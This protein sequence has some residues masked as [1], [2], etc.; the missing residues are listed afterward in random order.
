MRP[1]HISQNAYKILNRAFLTGC[2]FWIY[3]LE[4][5]NTF[6]RDP[7]MKEYL[8]KVIRLR[9]LWLEKFG[10]GI[11]RDDRGVVYADEGITAKVYLL[12]NDDVLV[13]MQ[14]N[15]VQQEFK[16]VLDVNKRKVKECLVYNLNG[17]KIRVEPEIEDGNA[18]IKT[19]TDHLALIHLA[20]I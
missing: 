8:K 18:V 3:D 1:V 13:A 15:N 12:S 9:K 17:A 10:K 16:L 19:K 6:K 11:Y 2:Y 7:E 20:F 5:E 14:N 4:E